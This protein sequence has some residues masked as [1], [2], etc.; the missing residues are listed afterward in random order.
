VE[1][2]QV[3]S[4]L[5]HQGRQTSELRP[6]EISI[7][8]RS[9]LAIIAFLSKGVDV[10]EAHL[11]GGRVYPT[12][13]ELQDW[14]EPVLPLHVRTSTAPPDA[15]YVAIQYREHWY[16]V[17]ESDLDSKRAFMLLMFL[18]ELLAPSGG[19][20]APLLTLPTG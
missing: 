5:G 13:S 8:T 7:Q 1:A 16:F 10:P 3:D 20:S 6:D 2:C 11:T 17:D 15:A 14:D 19:G 9:L 12:W 18:F 4:G